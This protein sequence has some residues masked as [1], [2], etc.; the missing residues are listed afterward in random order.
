M[1]EYIL[2]IQANDTDVGSVQGIFYNLISSEIAVTLD[3]TLGIIRSNGKFTPGKYNVKVMAIENT[4]EALSSSTEITINV[5]DVN[6]CSMINQPHSNDKILLNSTVPLGFLVTR[7]EAVDSDSGLEG[8]MI[9]SIK[10][11]EDLDILGVKE[12]SNEIVTIQYPLPIGQFKSYII[13]SDRSS[14]PCSSTATFYVFIEKGDEE[15]ELLTTT[16]EIS[17]TEKFDTTTE[18]F[19]STSN[20]NHLSE[21]VTTSQADIFQQGFVSYVIIGVITATTVLVILII[22]VVYFIIQNKKKLF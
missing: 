11:T 10:Q 13:V 22:S 12:N 2:Q 21:M 1:N 15:V 20:S 19:D 3:E 9:F 16:N 17:S 18:E 6:E 7:I 5:A 14:S 4:V 8:D